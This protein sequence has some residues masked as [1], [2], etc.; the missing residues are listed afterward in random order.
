MVIYVCACDESP[1]QAD[2]HANFIVNVLRT[3]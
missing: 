1:N 2:L 3:S